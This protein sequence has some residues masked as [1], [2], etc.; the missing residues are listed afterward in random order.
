[1]ATS[2]KPL[3]SPTKKVV[4][5]VVKTP[6]RS[7]TKAPTKP[8]KVA[9]ESVLKHKLVPAKRPALSFTIDLDAALQAAR[10]AGILTRSGKLSPK[11]R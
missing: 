8:F 7:N 11:Y 6:A 9:A 1:M 2:T 5:G 4:I 10:S 3:S